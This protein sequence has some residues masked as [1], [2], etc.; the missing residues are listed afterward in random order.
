MFETN[1]DLDI[2]LSSCLRRI[3]NR[4]IERKL[5]NNFGRVQTLECHLGS[6]SLRCV[7]V[8]QTGAM[9]VIGESG[10]ALCDTFD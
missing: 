7:T 2:D 10:Q 8:N 6:C 3:I 4:A 9:E 5:S 1:P